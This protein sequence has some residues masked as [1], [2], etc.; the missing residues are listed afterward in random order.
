MTKE[1]CF[2][3]LLPSFVKNEEEGKEIPYAE[4]VETRHDL[5]PL[6]SLLNHLGDPDEGPAFLQN[7][8]IYPPPP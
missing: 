6:R 5:T 4:A 2:A 3:L 1:E 8:F 7:R